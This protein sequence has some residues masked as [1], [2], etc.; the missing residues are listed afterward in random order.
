MTITKN[1]KYAELLKNTEIHVKHSVN[2]IERH[3]INI[4]LPPHV[5]MHQIGPWDIAKRAWVPLWP[6]VDLATGP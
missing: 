5:H 6:K 4:H 3:Q 1:T 2:R